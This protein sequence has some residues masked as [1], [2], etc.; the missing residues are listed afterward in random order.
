MCCSFPYAVNPF[1]GLP[2]GDTL[3]FQFYYP[4]NYSF[5]I[6]TLPQS[7]F[8]ELDIFIEPV[9]NTTTQVPT[10]TSISP[11]SV[12]VSYDNAVYSLDGTYNIYVDIPELDIYRLSIPV[13][14]EVQS[15][16]KSLMWLYT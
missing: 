8:D 6:G 5:V 15:E 13:T 7:F 4:I 16:W 14:L 3:P 11:S 12:F 2:G 9:D 10:I 1:I